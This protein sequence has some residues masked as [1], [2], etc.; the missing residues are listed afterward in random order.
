V[1]SRAPSSGTIRRSPSLDENTTFLFD[2]LSLKRYVYT[3]RPSLRAGSPAPVGITI[4][5][6]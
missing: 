2:I 4:Y 3:H 5:I 6:T 1:I